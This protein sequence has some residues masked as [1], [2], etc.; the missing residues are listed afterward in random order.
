VATDYRYPLPFPDEFYGGL[1]EYGRTRR[2]SVVPRP[3]FRE[4]TV[5]V[6]EREREDSDVAPEVAALNDLALA[7]AVKRIGGSLIEDLKGI[8]VKS[9]GMVHIYLFDDPR[10]AVDFSRTLRAQFR[11]QGVRLRIGVDTGR[12][13]LFDLAGGRRDVAGSPVNVASK[14]AQDGGR[15]DAITLT[16]AAAR[17]AGIPDVVAARGIKTGGVT[18]EA[19]VL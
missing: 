10:H 7:A 4:A 9:T 3:A 18:I 6:V 17:Q 16:A 11:E 12:M 5:V 1:H 13:L 15:F 19:I 8:E 14:L 2:S